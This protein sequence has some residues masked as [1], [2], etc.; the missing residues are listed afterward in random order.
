MKLFLLLMPALLLAQS[1]GLVVGVVEDRSGAV[2]PGAEVLVNNE[3]RK[4]VV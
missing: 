4:S 1:T 3:D 2:V